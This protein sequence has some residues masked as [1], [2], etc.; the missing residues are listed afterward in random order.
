MGLNALKKLLLFSILGIALSSP[1]ANRTLAPGHVPRVVRRLRSTGELAAE[2]RLNLAIG[3]PMH[4][5]KELD[6]LLRDLYDPGSPAFH[7]FLTT[8]EFTGQFG[9]TAEEYERVVEFAHAHHL[10]VTGTHANRLLLD[11]AGRAGD[12]NAAFGIHL[13]IFQRPDGT[14]SFFAPESEPVA[15]E[16]VPV[17]DVAGLSDYR[18]PQPQT[19]KSGLQAN[20]V[21]GYTS[22]QLRGAYAAGVTLDGSGQTIGLVEFD[23]FYASD[24]SNYAAATGL[25]PIS[26]QTVLLDGYNGVPTTGADSGNDEVS[27]DIEAAAAMAPGVSNII[28]YEAG[29]NGTPNDVLSRIATDDLAAQIACCWS[30]SGGPTASTDQILQQMAAQGQSFFCASGDSDAYTSANIDNPED[31]FTPCDSPYLT[32]VGGTVLSVAKT[33]NLWTGRQFGIGTRARAAAEESAP[34]IQFPPG[35]RG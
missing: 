24:I 12:V 21:T 9:P 3:L 14:G 27:L 22:A 26:V 29:E 30:W 16:E 7:Q 2:R 20:T 18:R 8:A 34:P 35:R 23:G 25:P 10:K 33:N 5:Q 15:P 17:L 6:R 19:R 4:R 1:A 32:S 31:E 28:S 13:R 11:V